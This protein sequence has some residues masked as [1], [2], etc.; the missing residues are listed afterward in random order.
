MIFTYWEGEPSAF[1]SLCIESLRRHGLDAVLSPAACA[2]L[3]AEFGPPAPPEL[4][5]KVPIPQR[6]DLIRFWALHALGG[7]WLDSDCIALAGLGQYEAEAETLDLW[8]HYNPHTKTGW[9]ASGMIPCFFGAKRGSEVMRWCWR[10]CL[11]LI[12]E[13]AAGHRVSYGATSV[14]VL[15][16]AYNHFKN[17]HRVVRREH[18]LLN[19][20]PWYD[21]RAVFLARGS[22]G[23]FA[24]TPWINSRVVCYHLTNV[25]G[26]VF[27]GK[28]REQILSSDRFVSY[29]LRKALNH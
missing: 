2:E 11:K 19:R 12:E 21:A 22:D 4:L 5:A 1:D 8:G 27:K 3:A 24:V 20:I 16:R 7:V 28:T 17:T 6:S 9:G 18:W 29:L 23:K 15:S 14:G 13:Q 10:E 25:V 26:K